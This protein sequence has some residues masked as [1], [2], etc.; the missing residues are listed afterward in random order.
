MDIREVKKSDLIN[1]LKLYMQLHDNP[2]PE[3]SDNLSF[4]AKSKNEA[5]LQN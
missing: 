1:L 4:F 3:K 2:L 5:S